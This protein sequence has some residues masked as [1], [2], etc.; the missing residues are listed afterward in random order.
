MG[1]SDSHSSF[2]WVYDHRNAPMNATTND[3]SPQRLRLLIVDDQ[4]LVRRGLALILA[5]D[6]G[7]EIIG[8]AADGIEAVEQAL[9][10]HPDIVL[11]DLQMPRSSGIVAT[12]KIKAQRPAIRIVVLTS[13]DNDALVF[14]AL[15]AGAQAYLLKDAAEAEILETLWTVQQGESH[16]SPTIARK[17]LEQFRLFA[18]RS[19]NPDSRSTD[20]NDMEQGH[21]A[22]PTPPIPSVVGGISTRDDD[23]LTD[24]EEQILQLLAQS[25]SNKQIAAALSFTEGTIKNYV[26]RI[27]CKLH[28]H[29]RIEL[30]MHAANRRR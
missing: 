30:A 13:Y 9:A 11:M 26:S 17:V 12:R 1:W 8:Q 18:S 4:P 23:S 15:C 7:I 22:F 3:Q 29:S 16:F 28:A 24:K 10:T 14:D 21:Y 6:P 25:K 2:K 20:S 19:G 27:M 5:D